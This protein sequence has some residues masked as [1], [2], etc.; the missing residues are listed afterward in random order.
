[1]KGSE[2]K[3]KEKAGKRRIQNWADLANMD[4][5][6]H[7]VEIEVQMF[8]IEIFIPHLVFQGSLQLQD[9]KYIKYNKNPLTLILEKM[10]MA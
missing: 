8:I 3:Q 6:V 7:N 10:P 2:N 9:K 1:M 4:V 5:A